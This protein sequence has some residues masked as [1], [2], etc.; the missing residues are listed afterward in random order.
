MEINIINSPN[1]LVNGLNEIE[2]IISWGRESLMST[3]NKKAVPIKSDKK[4]NSQ[5]LIMDFLYKLPLVIPVLSIICKIF[6]PNNTT[7]LSIIKL[8]AS[9]I[10]TMG[11]N[12]HIN[13]MG[14]ITLYI[15]TC[16]K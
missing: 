2:P 14:K 3:R 16:F 4:P 13:H 1:T 10:N 9:D 12:S 5:T 6:K 7:T 11:G 8:P 15:F